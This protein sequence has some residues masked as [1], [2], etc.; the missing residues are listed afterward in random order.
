MKKYLFGP[1]TV[2][3]LSFG[4]RGCFRGGGLAVDGGTGRGDVMCVW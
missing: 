4:P 3:K 2:I 1:T